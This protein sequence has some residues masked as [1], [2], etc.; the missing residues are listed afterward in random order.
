MSTTNLWPDL[1]PAV[2]LDVMYMYCKKYRTSMY[3]ISEQRKTRGFKLCCHKEF[4]VTT[5]NKMIMHKELIIM[6]LI[7]E[8]ATAESYWPSR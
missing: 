8:Q 4:S 3:I 1:T 6:I 7:G 5:I 2:S